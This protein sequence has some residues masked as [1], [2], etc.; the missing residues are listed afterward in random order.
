MKV[1]ATLIAFVLATACGQTPG[2][3]SPPVT[4][5]A[6]IVEA[7][8]PAPPPPIDATGETCGGI[9]GIQCP[10][11][12]YCQQPDGACIGEPDGAGTCQVKPEICTREYLPVCGCNGRTYPN[13]CEAAADGMSVAA[14]GPC[15]VPD[16]Q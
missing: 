13:A 14:E 2:E 6:P 4:E 7:A 11:T 3:P 12:Y 8:E 9:T 1:W 10:A 5:E 16:T 15:D